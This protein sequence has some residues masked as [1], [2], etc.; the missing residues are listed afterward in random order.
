MID[1]LPVILLLNPVD[2]HGIGLINEI[3]QGGERIAEADAATAPV[4][5][6]VHAFEFLV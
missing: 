3:E 1:Y 2:L 6:V 5:D 4:T